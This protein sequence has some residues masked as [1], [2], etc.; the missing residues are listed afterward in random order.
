MKKVRCFTYLGGRGKTGIDRAWKV[1]REEQRQSTWKVLKMVDGA[2]VVSW[3]VFLKMADAGHQVRLCSRVS[4]HARH[5]AAVL[6]ERVD[7]RLASLRVG[8]QLGVREVIDGC[9]A[10]KGHQ[11]DDW[12]RLTE[13]KEL[14][15]D[16]QLFLWSHH[17]PAIQHLPTGILVKK[18]VL[19]LPFSS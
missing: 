2:I 15:E 19:Y 16:E 8:V 5:P 17:Q 12:A 10:L 18:K 11:L 9:Q 13:T 7:I 14:F 4:P 3:I 6:D 1:E